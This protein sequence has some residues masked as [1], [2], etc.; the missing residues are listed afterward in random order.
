M[1][2]VLRS[3]L[4]RAKSPKRAFYNLAIIKITDGYL[5]RKESGAGNK[6]LHREAWFRETLEGAVRLYEK[7]LREKT[8]PKRRS[9]R[10]YTVVS[11]NSG[12]LSCSL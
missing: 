3:T 2:E 8:N 1:K 11:Q 9:P 6:V 4:L 5:V 12:S 7:I 10:K